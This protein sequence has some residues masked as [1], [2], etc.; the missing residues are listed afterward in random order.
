MSSTSTR[1]SKP[2]TTSAIITGCIAGGIEAVC[3]WPMEYMK[4]QLQLQTKAP[5]VKPPFTGVISGILYTVKTTGFFS[6]YNGLGVTLLFSVPKAGI[7][8]GANSQCK[9]MLADDQ[10]K[11]TMGKNFLAG[12]G[13]GVVEA[14]LAVTPMESIKT[15]T[16]EKNMGLVG[17]VRLILRES[18]V[19]GLYKG[20][21]ATI[22]KQSSNQGL[23]FMFFNKY[24]ELAT[25]DGAEKLSPQG[26]LLGGML[27]GCFSTC[28]NNPFDMVKTRM[29]GTQSSRY[30]STADCFKQV[31]QKEGFAAFYAGVVPRLGRV[32]PGQGIIFMSF[33]T[34]Q[35]F[36]Q[37]ALV[38]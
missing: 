36:V 26:A 4:T 28:L 13:A 12:V 8:F 14:V 11:L 30:S 34:I 20:L 24:K 6:L 19:G 5:G 9:K 27:A 15:V 2:S 38:K 3:V 29:Q 21:A 18:G 22:L 32:V 37:D 33:E 16:I 23:R 1:T 10:G 7:R 35:V 25:Q 31:L 17:A